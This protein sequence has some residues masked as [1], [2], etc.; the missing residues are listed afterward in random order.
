MKMRSLCLSVL[1]SLST[2]YADSSNLPHLDPEMTGAEYRA[3]F[4]QKNLSF[5]TDELQVILTVGK[6]NLDWLEKINRARS[7]NSQMDLWTEANT[8]A[9][10]I[11]TP[12]IAN[13]TLIKNRY[14]TLLSELPNEMKSVVLSSSELPTT[15]PFADEIYLEWARKLDKIYQ[16]ASRWLL[17]EPNLFAYR[18]RAKDD[19]R[20]FVVL[21]KETDLAT[22]LAQWN[23]LDEATK[24]RLKMAL[25]GLCKNSD[26]AMSR[27]SQE[28]TRETTSG[29]ASAFYAKYI[30]RSRSLYNSF[31]TLTNARRDLRWSEAENTCRMPFQMPETNEIRS[32]LADNIE[33]EWK[34]N[35]WSF[36][37]EFAANAS[38]FVR[39]VAGATPNVNGLGGNR[40]TMDANRPI[41]HY[42]TKWTIR[43]EFGH[44][45]GFPDCYIEFYDSDEGVMV[46]YQLDIT[47]L[48]CSRRGKLQEKHYLEMKRSY[49]SN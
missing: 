34:W 10:P 15:A 42:S 3:I 20:G 5:A 30:A 11:E 9:Y 36:K 22:K 46:N 14:T 21:S 47:N 38:A 1:L 24:E 37:L 16:A 31:F 18:A 6:R 41:D 12:S 44:V 35:G 32:W 26:T 45:L 29:T 25:L 48:M 40:I 43:H 4:Q 17:Q 13:R 49:G 2:S 7:A 23:T 39:F 19:V 28:F 8:Q 27:C 33:D